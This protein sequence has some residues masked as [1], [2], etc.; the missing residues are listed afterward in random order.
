[1]LQRHIGHLN[2]RANQPVL[3]VKRKLWRRD[4]DHAAIKDQAFDTIRTAVLKRDVYTCR[5]CQFQASK[6]QEVH[7]L[8][9][10]HAN[11]TGDNLITACTLCHQVHH[12]GMCGVRNGGFIAAI[13]ELTQTEINHIV[14]GI[15]VQDLIETQEVRD[16][17]KSLLALFELRG[18]D[19]LKN[20]YGTDLRD[21][22]T[23]GQILSDLPDDLYEK[24]A[25]ILAPL[26]LVPT[27]EAF[28]EGQ[29]DYY[30]A[31]KT[32]A[33]KADTWKALCHQLLAT[34]A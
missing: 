25:E 11:N 5:F 2:R 19:T 13:P 7:H 14:R 34:L 33:M 10:D 1:M 21:A 20:I 18:T 12:L 15:Y 27:V 32:A 16:K 24:R 29:L 22:L 17:N 8:D 28:N 4:D 30:A 26:R 6:Y 3:S 9:D 23:W 31:N